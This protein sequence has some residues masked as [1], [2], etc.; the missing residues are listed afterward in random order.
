MWAEVAPLWPQIQRLHLSRPLRFN[1][2]P[3]WQYRGYS[4]H[5]LSIGAP[6]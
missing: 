5:E 1:V 3:H 2:G 6:G 4:V